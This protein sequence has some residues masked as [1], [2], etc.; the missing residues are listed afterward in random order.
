MIVYK[1]V[2]FVTAA[3][4]IRQASLP[5]YIS[6]NG[7]PS[8]NKLDL[9]NSK[10]GRSS[11]SRQKSPKRNR[12][13]L[14]YD[15]E[16]DLPSKKVDRAINNFENSKKKLQPNDVDSPSTSNKKR[17]SVDSDEEVISEQKVKRK[18]TKP[19]TDESD[20]EVVVE[21][22]PK[23]LRSKPFK[24][25]LE[26]VVFVMSGYQNPLRADIRNKALAMGAKYKPDWVNGPGGCTHLM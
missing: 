2:Y 22:K 4:E 15:E 20:D 17:K 9:N 26:G 23:T 8:I 25:L 1:K 19:I 10:T 24:Q 12:N 14:L 18:V 3:H 13:S 11:N 16:D 6:Q 21:K 5:T 7:S